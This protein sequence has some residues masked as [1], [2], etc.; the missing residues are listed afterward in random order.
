MGAS[1]VEAFLTSLAID[2]NVAVSTQ[3]QAFSALMFPYQEL[4]QNPIV[5]SIYL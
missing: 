5:T 3:S 1:E 4:L 2:R